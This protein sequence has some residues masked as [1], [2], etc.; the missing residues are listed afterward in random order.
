MLR[1][2]NTVAYLPKEKS[3]VNKSDSHLVTE[4]YYCTY[5]GPVK[6]RLS[7][8]DKL[9]IF[10]PDPHATYNARLKKD[11]EKTAT[12]AEGEG[13]KKNSAYFENLYHY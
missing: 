10:T 6:G 1:K 11:Q 3:Q 7:V 9:L 12:A 13:K 8:S 2:M 5:H 4:A